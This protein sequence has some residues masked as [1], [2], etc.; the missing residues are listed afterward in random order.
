MKVYMVLYLNIG[1]IMSQN[2][3]FRI[4]F[5]LNMQREAVIIN[6]L[7]YTTAVQKL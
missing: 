6:I 2:L 1:I 3:F 5:F 4:C 7:K